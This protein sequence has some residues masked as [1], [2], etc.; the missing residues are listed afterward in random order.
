M[1]SPLSHP[2]ALAKTKK[3]HLITIYPVFLKYCTHF[4][5][6]PPSLG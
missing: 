6:H 3:I 5:S 4:K 1:D 2:A